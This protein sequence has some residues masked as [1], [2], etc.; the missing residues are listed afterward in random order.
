VGIPAFFN[1][2]GVILNILFRLYPK[3]FFA[4]TFTLY[5]KFNKKVTPKPVKYLIRR[6]MGVKREVTKVN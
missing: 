6:E 1:L 3:M 5:L 2:S 4:L